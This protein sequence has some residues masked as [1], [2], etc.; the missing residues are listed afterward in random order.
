M[1]ILLQGGIAM[2]AAQLLLAWLGTVA[3]WFVVPGVDGG[4]VKDYGTL[5]KGHIDYV[6]MSLYCFS[7]YG[8]AKSFGVI[9]PSFV[10]M[11]IVIGGMTNPSI[12]V[13]A[14]FKPDFWSR[15]VWKIYTAF[16]FVITTTGFVLACYFLGK[17]L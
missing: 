4:I 17:A 5:V 6:L 7:L 15:P 16:S 12:F 14:T 13:I 1:T 11:L 2:I 9:L 8:A 3:R 10:C